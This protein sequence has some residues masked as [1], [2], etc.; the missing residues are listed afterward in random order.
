MRLRHIVASAGRREGVDPCPRPNLT[1]KKIWRQRRSV[2]IPGSQSWEAPKLGSL[3]N[4]LSDVMYNWRFLCPA[5][6]AENFCSSFQTPTFHAASPGQATNGCAARQ[7]LAANCQA[8]HHSRRLIG[9]FLVFPMETTGGSPQR[10]LDPSPVDPAYWRPW[11]VFF[12]GSPVPKI[13]APRVCCTFNQPT[14]VV[15]LFHGICFDSQRLGCRSRNAKIWLFS[16][17]PGSNLRFAARPN[18]ID[19][20]AACL[21]GQT[22]RLPDSANCIGFRKS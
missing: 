11:L 2:P 18:S 19:R 21:P 14:C 16:P 9:H 22:L 5:S 6:L 17:L 1:P 3:G 13:T 8:L 12:T 10:M 4:L 7:R 20:Y 15:D